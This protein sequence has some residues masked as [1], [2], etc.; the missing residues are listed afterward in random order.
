MVGTCSGI[1]AGQFGKF[2]TAKF[3][4]LSPENKSQLN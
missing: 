1:Y 4:S 3:N 2:L